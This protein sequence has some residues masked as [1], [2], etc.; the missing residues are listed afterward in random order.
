MLRKIIY[1]MNKD[2]H[3]LHALKVLRQSTFIGRM[4]PPKYKTERHCKSFLPAAVRPSFKI[5]YGFNVNVN[6]RDLIRDLITE[7]IYFTKQKCI[8]S[9]LNLY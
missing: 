5:S 7:I 2:M 1:N 9:S 8:Y 4:I 6:T 3:L